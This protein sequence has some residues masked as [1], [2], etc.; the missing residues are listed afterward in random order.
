LKI[1]LQSLPKPGGEIGHAIAVRL[2][3][4]GAHVACVSRTEKNAK[5]TADEIN[6]ARAGAA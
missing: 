2:A 4:E 5:K 3:R 1:R 6:T